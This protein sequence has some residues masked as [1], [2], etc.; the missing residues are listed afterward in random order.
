LYFI[1]LFLLFLSVFSIQNF[2][3]PPFNLFLHPKNFY[4]FRSP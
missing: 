2:F 1:K 3:F 4:F